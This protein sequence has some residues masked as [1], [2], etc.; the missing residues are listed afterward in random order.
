VISVGGVKLPAAS[1]VTDRSP[2]TTT[3]VSVVGASAEAF[4]AA[5]CRYP[6]KP[7]AAIMT[8]T[9]TIQMF[10]FFMSFFLFIQMSLVI[11]EGCFIFPYDFCRKKRSKMLFEYPRHLPTKVG[12]LSIGMA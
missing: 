7:S 1:T 3:A 8:T 4:L 11:I 5:I 9:A 12:T 10:F 6:I 2:R